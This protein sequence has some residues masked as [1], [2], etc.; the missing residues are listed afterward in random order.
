ME[1]SDATEKIPSDTTGDR[2]RELLRV[3][4][5]KSYKV[6][7]LLLSMLH[8]CIVVNGWQALYAVDLHMLLL[9]MIIS[10]P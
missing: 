10:K 9:V 1:L 3:I 7:P 2:S 6:A 4:K 8:D 5:H